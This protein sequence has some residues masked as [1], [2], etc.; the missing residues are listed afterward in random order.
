MLVFDFNQREKV[1]KKVFKYSTHVV[2]PLIYPTLFIILKV[3]FLNNQNQERGIIILNLVIFSSFIAIF[4]FT[5][6]KTYFMLKN[7]C[8]FV[9]LQSQKYLIM[10]FI[11]F[12]STII[13]QISNGYLIPWFYYAPSSVQMHLHQFDGTSNSSMYFVIC[14]VIQ[15]KLISILNGYLIMKFKLNNDIIQGVSKLDYYIKISIFQ[16]NKNMPQEPEEQQMLAFSVSESQISTDPYDKLVKDD[17][18]ILYKLP[19][20]V[21][22]SS[23]FIGR[24]S[25][26]EVPK[27]EEEYEITT[28]DGS[29]EKSW[30]QRN[31]RSSSSSF[32]EKREEKLEMR[33]KYHPGKKG[34][35]YNNNQH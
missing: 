10:Y 28:T 32:G 6:L 1:M 27:I 11:L 12:L 20:E 33:G 31:F 23:S 4:V 7:Q 16:K 13:I 34:S 21:N 17:S 29:V 22:N 9:F 30:A 8:N 24:S 25:E 19:S 3:I 35:F 18:T 5:F 26:K 15:P 14:F 2:L